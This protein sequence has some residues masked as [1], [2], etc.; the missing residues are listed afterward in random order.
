[1][2]LYYR[3]AELG[4]TEAVFLDPVAAALA[5]AIMKFRKQETEKHGV[6]TRKQNRFLE[7]GGQYV[8]N[9]LPEPET[10]NEKILKVVK[11]YYTPGEITSW[12]CNKLTAKL[13]TRDI[14]GE[15]YVVRVYG[16][17]ENLDEIHNPKFWNP[18]PQ[19]FVVKGVLG[20]YGRFVRVI[21]KNNPKTIETLHGL[22]NAKYSR[23]TEERYIVEEFLP[24]L[25]EGR[26]ITDYKFFCTFG[27]VLFVA[28]GDGPDNPGQISVEEKRKSLFTVPGW[29][30]LN[31]TYCGRT[32]TPMPKPAKLAEMTEVAQ[33]LSTRFPFIR[34][35][36]YLTRDS[37]GQLVVKVGELTT[38]PAWGCGVFRPAGFDF[39]AGTLISPMSEVD[40]DALKSNDAGYIEQWAA[41]LQ[42][43]PD[44]MHGLVVPGFTCHP[45]IK[46]DSRTRWKRT[47]AGPLGATADSTPSSEYFT[48]IKKNSPD[49][50]IPNAEV[51]TWGTPFHRFEVAATG[52]TQG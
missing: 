25:V 10:L 15:K 13:I 32:Q 31:V 16:A 38:L 39:L 7:K 11:E 23:V 41:K 2:K 28:V 12:I 1:M 4:G 18:L 34:I 49:W 45:K 36:L 44:P 43:S 20:S 5:D 22:E 42:K 40:F 51:I 47:T 46:F 26:T 17:V 50:G 48:K 6:L 14:I 30:L 24:S 21:D 52:S 29:Q 3:I 9:F 19:K 8:L 27:K 35:D 33:K 37:A